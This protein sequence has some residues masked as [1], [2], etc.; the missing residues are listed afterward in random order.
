MHPAPRL[1][2]QLPQW[3][4]RLLLLL[5]LLLQTCPHYFH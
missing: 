5:L 2:L 3:P 1:L 4:Q